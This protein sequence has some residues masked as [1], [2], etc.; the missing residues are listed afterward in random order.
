MATSTILSLTDQIREEVTCDPIPSAHGHARLLQLV[1]ELKLAI[2]T[3][4]ETVLR[5]IYQ[6]PENAA[7]RTVVD[8]GIFPLLVRDGQKDGLT[9]TDIALC[10]GADRALIVRLMR[11]MS[12]LGLCT[13]IEPE[14][15][16][17]NEKTIPMTQPLG[18]DGVPCIYDLTVPTLTKLP[19]YLREHNYINPEEYT[20]S[21][22]QWAV[23]QSQFEWLAKKKRH[24]ALF[25]SYMSSRR[26]GKP[27]WF[28]V[29]PLERLIDGAS[30]H[31]EAVFLVDIGGNQGHDLGRFVSGYRS[32]PGRLILQDLPKIVSTV[33]R[34]GIETMGY[35]FLDPQPV[36]N[37]RAYYFRAI[38]HDWPDH[39][40]QKILLN[41][42]AAMDP[43]YSR[44]II[45]DFVLPDT[46]AG[47]MQS[48]M[49]IQMM[50]IGAGVERSKRQW[51]E[52]LAS[53]GLRINGIWNFSPGME[54]IIEVV[55]ALGAP[56]NE[57]D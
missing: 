20:S 16:R 15:Y 33:D 14:I 6:P 28:D 32:K 57:L 50:S 38:F 22:M 41:T 4:T 27:N 51:T 35:S 43:T 40:C 37:A 19:E 44:I 47:R 54:S 11:V 25:N 5:L 56:V 49:D 46:N 39:I 48:A 23:G 1:D 9:A 30:S 3:P 2:E 52:L 13:N 42:A 7:L 29:Y 10:T 26:E 31:P 36:K 17:P 53:V 34:T 55:P 12:A 18:Q 24:Q 8:L 45:V 21:P